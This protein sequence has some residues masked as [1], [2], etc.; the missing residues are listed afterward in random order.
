VKTTHVNDNV[1]SGELP[2]IEVKPVVRNLNLIS[3]HNFLLENTISVSEAIAPSRVVE[4]RE[5]VQEASSK[6]T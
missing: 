1:V 2:G 5:R 4:R 6:S 3:I